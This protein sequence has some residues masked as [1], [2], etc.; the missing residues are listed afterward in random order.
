MTDN[1]WIAGGLLT[2]IIG[3]WF[4]GYL[5]GFNKLKGF[6]AKESERLDALLEWVNNHMQLKGYENWQ[7]IITRDSIDRGLDNIFRGLF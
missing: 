5:C 4:V 6:N 7:V 2:L 1:F 3:C